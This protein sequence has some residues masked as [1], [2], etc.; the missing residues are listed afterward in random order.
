M[1]KSASEFVSRVRPGVPGL[2]RPSGAAPLRIALVSPRF[3]PSF[4]GMNYSLPLLPGGAR[5]QSL[6]GALPLLAALTPDPHVVDLFDEEIET[7]DFEKL[8]SY[9][10]IGLTGM[11]VQR[12]QMLS[13]LDT[14][15]DYEGILAVGG[16]YASVDEGC[17]SHTC[18][19]VFIG[20][21]DVTWPE[22]LRDLES[23]KPCRTRYEQSE[24]TDMT[25]LP[26]PRFDLMRRSVYA[27]GTLQFSRGCPF[28]CDFCDI[29]TIFGR[30]PRTKTPDQVLRELDGLLAAGFRRVFLVDDNFIG[31]KKEALALLPHIVDW[32]KARGYPLS[33]STEASVNLADEPELL[34]LMHEAG[35]LNV[36]IG[37]ESP[38]AETLAGMRKGQNMR[39]DSLQAKIGRVRDAG[40]LVT[41]GFMLGFDSDTTD[42]FDQQEAFISSTNLAVVAVGILTAIPTTPL[43]DRLEKEGRLRLD[44][45]YCNFLPKNMTAEQLR[46]GYISL[47]QRLFEPDAYFAR[48]FGVRSSSPALV[49]KLRQRSSW[50]GRHLERFS[51]ANAALTILIRLAKTMNREGLLRKVGG[52]YVRAYL[53]WRRQGA[54]YRVDLATYIAACAQ[55]WHFYKFYRDATVDAAASTNTYSFTRSTAA[56]AQRSPQP[57][58]KVDEHA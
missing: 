50:A 38:N 12:R 11:I 44:D 14:L 53:R 20:E 55:H 52:E 15:H 58:I 27:T 19:V 49:D 34:R 56:P 33:L 26:L 35:F 8:R 54:V 48:W 3:E 16:P 25:T 9:D 4:F 17:F 18:D 5:T 13:I 29:I 24:K 30:R 45:P 7:L 22:F 23:G 39:G 43:Y 37:I 32:Q 47:N 41:A 6:V 10:V 28:L 31:N 46:A 51:G 36:F 2:S 40:I 21:A 57:S 1:I 42:V